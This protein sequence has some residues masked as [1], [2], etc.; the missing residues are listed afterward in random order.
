MTG[1]WPNLVMYNVDRTYVARRR[2]TSLVFDIATMT[3][4][5][6]VAERSGGNEHQAMAA[7]ANHGQV[8]QRN[9]NGAEERRFS[10][11]PPIFRTLII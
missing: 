6:E 10:A 2:P 5:A 11:S 9:A 7:R 3:R 1:D 4:S 8:V